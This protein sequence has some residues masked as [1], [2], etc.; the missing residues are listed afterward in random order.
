M[1]ASKNFRGDKMLE[2]ISVIGRVNSVMS[3]YLTV[4]PAWIAGVNSV[5]FGVNGEI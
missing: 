3:E 2:L 1:N 4:A 5:N